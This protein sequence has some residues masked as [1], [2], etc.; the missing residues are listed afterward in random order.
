MLKAE[1]PIPVG[2]AR[3]AAPLVVIAFRAPEVAA[4]PIRDALPPEVTKTRSGI[5]SGSYRAGLISLKT[6]G[7]YSGRRSLAPLDT[8]PKACPR[9]SP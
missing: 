9:R 8:R 6:L 7:N 3:A 4:F 1:G 2:D 5:L